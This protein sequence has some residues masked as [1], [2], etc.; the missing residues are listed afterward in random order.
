MR[1][2]EAPFRW[3]RG[4]TIRPDIASLQAYSIVGAEQRPAAPR[5]CFASGAAKTW[6]QAAGICASVIGFLGFGGSFGGFG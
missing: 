5:Y 4:L 3:S 1:Q 6:R 2:A